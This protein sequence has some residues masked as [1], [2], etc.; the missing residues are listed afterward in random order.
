MGP[1]FSTELYVELRRKESAS[2][3]RRDISSALHKESIRV[4]DEKPAGPTVDLPDRRVTLSH[5]F[6][7]PSETVEL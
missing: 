2:S 5:V 7:R 4:T 1:M 3:R 6:V